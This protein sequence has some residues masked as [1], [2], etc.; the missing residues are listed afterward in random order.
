M[1]QSPLRPLPEATVSHLRSTINIV[2]LADVLKE[3]IQNALDASATRV[4]CSVNLERWGVRVSDDGH[5][6]DRTAVEAV[7][8]RYSACRQLAIRLPSAE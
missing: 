7:A 5:G 1:A 2:S 3:L 8:E 4:D 6:M